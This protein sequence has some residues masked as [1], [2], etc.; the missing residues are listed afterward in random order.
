MDNLAAGGLVERRADQRR[1]LR[2]LRVQ[3]HAADLCDA[4]PTE[5]RML[6]V[7]HALA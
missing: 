4:P 7:H 2:Q 3:L 1:Q 6:A 5:T